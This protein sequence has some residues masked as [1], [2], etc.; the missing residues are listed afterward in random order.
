[1]ITLL[2]CTALLSSAEVSSVATSSGTAAPVPGETD[3]C[4][5]GPW[6]A[7]CTSTGA[8]T[9]TVDCGAA[10]ESWG[11]A[12]AEAI[13]LPLGGFGSW[14]GDHPADDCSFGDGAADDDEAE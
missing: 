1:M 12:L 13:F 11:L 3:P 2:A 9:A 6:Q 7:S 10:G 5:P 8:L 14:R 4:W